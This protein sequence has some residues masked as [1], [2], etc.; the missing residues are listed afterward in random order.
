MTV[1]A[2]GSVKVS[3]RSGANVTRVHTHMRSCH[4]C[5]DYQNRLDQSLRAGLPNKGRLSQEAF[6]GF[7]G[8]GTPDCQ[9]Q[10]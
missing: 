3:V 8:N 1:T 2:Y 7:N 5:V 4:Y 10:L 6:R 9:I